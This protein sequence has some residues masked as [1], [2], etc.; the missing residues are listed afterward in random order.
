ME[1]ITSYYRRALEQRNSKATA[2]A[3][4]P[5]ING[6]PLW[7]VVLYPLLALALSLLLAVVA[8]LSQR[9][10]NVQKLAADFSGGLAV[11]FFVVSVIGLMGDMRILEIVAPLMG[12]DPYDPFVLAALK[13]G[14]SINL[15]LTA[16]FTFIGGILMLLGIGIGA[17]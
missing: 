6:K 3:D 14:K 5:P 7:L 12:H 1:A 15:G 17:A 10:L 13:Y 9:S 2:G 11:G 16:F 8:I 4:I